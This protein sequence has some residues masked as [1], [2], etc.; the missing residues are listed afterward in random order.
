MLGIA[1]K[2]VIKS[3]MNIGIILPFRLKIF[4]EEMFLNWT[5]RQFVESSNEE[6]FL[7][8]RA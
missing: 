3:E 6:M 4:W 8:V 2:I 1:N 5:L 7:S